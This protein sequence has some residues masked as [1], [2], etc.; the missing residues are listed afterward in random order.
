M[1]VVLLIKLTARFESLSETHSLPR[2]SQKG[3]AC[4]VVEMGEGVATTW[5]AHPVAHLGPI[6]ETRRPRTPHA[7][8]HDAHSPMHSNEY[9][10]YDNGETEA[11]S[12]KMKKEFFSFNPSYRIKTL[13]NF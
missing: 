9:H 11:S 1:K 4:M 3:K 12:C 13:A 8:M 5:S 2:Q 10:F 7:P 6:K